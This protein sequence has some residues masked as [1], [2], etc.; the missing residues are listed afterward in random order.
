MAGKAK[1][2]TTEEIQGIADALDTHISQLDRASRDPKKPEQV[3]KVY[4]R[5]VSLFRKLKQR[6]ILTD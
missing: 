5:E 3:R 1:E 4:E 6:V 2:F